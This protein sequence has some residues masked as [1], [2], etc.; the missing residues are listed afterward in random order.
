MKLLSL[1]ITVLNDLQV[2]TKMGTFDEQ[3]NGTFKHTWVSHQ[4][5]PDELV[6]FPSS[7]FAID[8]N[9]TFE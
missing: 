4:G 5:N 6:Y 7:T 9:R 8:A 3:T 1:L 2:I